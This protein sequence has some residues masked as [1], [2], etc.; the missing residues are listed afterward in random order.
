M[1]AVA[2]GGAVAW[3][4]R[5]RARQSDVIT[6]EW[7]QVPRGRWLLPDLD[8]ARLVVPDRPHSL[9]EAMANPGQ[10]PFSR[11]RA[12]LVSSNADRI[13]GERPLSPK[14]SGLRRWLALGDSVTFGWGV[15]D[16]ESWPAQLEAQL[17][18]Q[19]HAV[20]ILN[21]G[22]PA[23]RIDAMAQFLESVAPRLELDGVLLAERPETGVQ[24]YLRELTR[25]MKPLGDTPLMLMLPPI[26]RFDPHGRS[27]W[28]REG[29]ELRR[30]LGARAP[31]VDLTRE[32]WAAQEGKGVD[33]Q[34]EGQIL[35]MVD[36]QGRLIVEASLPQ[37][38]LPREI[39][40]AFEDDHSLREGLFLDEGHPDA[41]GFGVLCELLA[42]RIE[43]AGWLS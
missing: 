20:E 25:G 17:A 2:G 10:V 11:R 38:D 21:Y 28:E 43:E 42:P 12:C 33:L 14:A 29:A 41:A 40:E 22:V 19:G 18:S 4:R 31:V 37:D 8:E 30:G 35:H 23:Q 32:L 36:A 3:Q 24:G 6:G 7:D 34:I 16:T 39:Y 15:E 5:R 26:S 27:A 9:A 1:S 13:R